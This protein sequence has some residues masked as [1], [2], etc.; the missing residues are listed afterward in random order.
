[1]LRAVAVERL[2]KQLEGL[3][4]LVCECTAASLLYKVSMEAL[5]YETEVS[6]LMAIL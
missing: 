2:R 1:M 5:E 4:G 6:D 3:S